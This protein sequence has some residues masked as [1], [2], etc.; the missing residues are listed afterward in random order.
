[1]TGTPRATASSIAATPADG[2]GDLDVEVRAINEGAQPQRG[3]DGSGGVVGQRRV[4][5]ERDEA[6]EAVGGAVESSEA[7]AGVADVGHD[8]GERELA[9][10]RARSG[11]QSD[12]G[13][14]GG[15]GRDCVLEDRRIRGG[16]GDGALADEAV[17]LAAVDQGSRECVEPHALTGGG[18]SLE[19]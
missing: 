10:V 5:F 15:A 18:E 11:G 7:V 12:V 19:G 6:V 8:Q 13:V 9:G 4:D 2:R 17:E 16:A 1:M 3:R 14:V